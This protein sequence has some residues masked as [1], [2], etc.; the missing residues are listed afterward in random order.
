MDGG[1][2]GGNEG[3]G[4]A[5]NDRS[6]GASDERGGKEGRKE[7]HAAAAFSDDCSERECS[8]FVRSRGRFSSSAA[9]L[10]LLPSLV[11]GGKGRK[12]KGKGDGPNWHRIGEQE[13]SDGY[14]FATQRYEIT[15][16]R[17]PLVCS[18]AALHLNHRHS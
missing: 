1:R 14:H 15:L 12:K 18:I 7:Q 17:R 13:A 4:E 11:N 3:G 9:P 5:A 2:E 6:E 16:L 10:F 8:A